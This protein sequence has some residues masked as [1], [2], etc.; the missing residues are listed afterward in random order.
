[1]GD[2][3]EI[4]HV[5]EKF[6]SVPPNQVRINIFK[7]YVNN[8]GLMDLGYNGPA[9]TWSNKQHGKDLVLQRLDRCLANVEWCMNFPNTTVY[10]LPMLY[11]DHAPII[12]I[13]NPKSRRPRR[14][15]KFENWW[16]L[17]SDFNQEAKA[18]WQKTE[19]YHFQRRTTLLARFLTSW[20][21][22]KKPLQ[23][24]LDQIENDLLKIQDSPN[25]DLY[26]IEEQ[27]LEQ[28]HDSTMQ[29]LADYYK[30]RSKKHWVQQG[31]RNTSFFHQAAQKR[32]RKN[33]ISTIIQNNSI[34]NDPDE[35]ATAFISYFSNLFQ[36][37]NENEASS[38]HGTND[39]SEIFLPPDPPNEDE[40]LQILKQMKR[41]AS[42][43]PDGLNVAFYRAAWQW[44]KEDVTKMVAQFYETANYIQDKLPDLIADTQQAF[45]KGRRISN[46]IV[47]AQEIAHSFNLTSYD[48]KAFLLKI[49]LSKAFDRIE[50]SF[51]ADALR[52]KGFHGNFIR[53][54][55]SCINSANF[56]VIINGQSYGY[57]S[58]QRGIRQGCPLS[59]YLFVLAINELS[60]QLTEAIQ[61]EYISGIKLGPNG[62]PIHSLMYADDLIITGQA[63]VE[64][65]QKISDIIRDFCNKSGQT[66]N[67]SK[68]SILFSAKTPEKARQ[69]ILHIFPVSLINH[70]TKHLG[71]PILL[72]SKNRKAA[73]HFIVDKFKRIQADGGR[74]GMALKSWDDICKPI[75]EG[76]LGIRDLMAVREILEEASIWQISQGTRCYVDAS[77]KEGK[78]GIGIFIHNPE[79]HNTIV[80]K[81]TS[82]MSGSPLL[83][84][85][86]AL[87]LAI[88]ICHQ[89]QIQSPV[90]LSDNI[91]VVN[92]IQ[93]EDYMTDP[94][95]WSLRPALSRIHNILQGRNIKIQWIPREMN[96]MA[97]NLAKSARELSSQSQM[98]F[99]CS[100]I[101]HIC[102]NSGC[103]TRRG[104]LL[105]PNED[106]TIAHALCF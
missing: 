20:S 96:K 8:I 84:E 83:A 1:M 41:D 97:D 64:E 16:L 89:L 80:I 21:K 14:S 65:A 10:H 34:T 101:S 9:Y 77:W 60:N 35:I 27:R 11:S 75:A 44:I 66:P 3:N 13:L 69:D 48:Q 19:R 18:A 43:G 70:S 50:W 36:S 24:Q 52:R 81:A 61:R 56:S 33:R 87:M 54:V 106:V 17:E 95:H 51:I 73:Y 38:S 46:N 22:K 4:M 23:Q 32:R 58:A 63:Q 45:V 71:H 72:G 88:Q 39:Q 49:D 7:H 98:A 28:Q 92:A 55:L 93:K 67:W 94:G 100:N 99:D 31:D 47:I 90:F 12:A 53:L 42:P 68:S 102:H 103:P 30:Q 57:F 78:T 6:G 74:K 82:S 25:R 76:G 5:N 86:N 104:L 85:M 2:L 62:P 29:K 105:T 15:F 91:M 40:I 26:Q 79:N 59:P 37:T